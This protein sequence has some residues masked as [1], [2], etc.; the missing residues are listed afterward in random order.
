MLNFPNRIRNWQ[1]H[2]RVRSQ[3]FPMELDDKNFWVG[4]MATKAK[5]NQV[6]R[7]TG[8]KKCFMNIHSEDSMSLACSVTR[9]VW[10]H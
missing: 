1:K 5:Y 9:R 10:Y 7:L 6:F 2:V 8:D 3:C 4:L